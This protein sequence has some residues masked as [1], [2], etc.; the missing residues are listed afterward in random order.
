M[1][2]FALLACMAQKGVNV[3]QPQDFQAYLGQ[4]ITIQ[5]IALRSKAGVFLVSEGQEIW[6]VDYDWKAEEYEKKVEVRG[7][8]S[9][10]RDPI[11]AFPVATKDENGAWSQGTGGIGSSELQPKI[12]VSQ[13][14]FLEV[15]S[16]SIV[17]K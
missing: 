9:Q 15:Q 5:G 3:I 4:E 12:A 1:N 8:L 17:E 7:K 10:G 6:I 2:L 16:V 14:W 13:T 11:S